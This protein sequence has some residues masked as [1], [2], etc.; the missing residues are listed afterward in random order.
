MDALKR[1]EDLEKQLAFERA[2]SAEASLLARTSERDRSIEEKARLQSELESEAQAKSAADKAFSRLHVRHARPK[3][4]EA[5]SQD[6]V[7]ALKSELGDDEDSVT[8][9]MLARDQHGRSVL[10]VA[11][12]NAAQNV[13]RYLI[14]EAGS[15]AL[16]CRDDCGHSPLLTLS[17]CS[18]ADPE[19]A[20]QLLSARA[21]PLH[22]DL[23]GMTPFLECARMGHVDIGRLLLETAN[24][25]PLSDVD[26]CGRSPVHWAVESRHLRFVEFL[27]ECQA[28]TDLL[29]KQGISP[30]D[31]A[32]KIDDKD[33]RIAQLLQ[34]NVESACQVE[35]ALEDE[36]AD[37]SAGVF[38]S[39]MGSLFQKKRTEFDFNS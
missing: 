3:L 15:W 6:N 14:L 13:A 20:A 26:T 31:L 39:F 25:K 35:A 12:A 28:P 30:L 32:L 16:N 10:H 36:D 11:L 38:S 37:T 5:A 22:R 34:S 4:F 9:L 1:E 23:E 17:R 19:I 29:D 24:T 18:N 7:A 21:S 8:A 27:I 33:G 2:A